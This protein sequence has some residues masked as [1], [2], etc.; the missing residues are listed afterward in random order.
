[1][2]ARIANLLCLLVALIWGGGFI[3]TDLA[4]ESFS[5][6]SMLVC[7]FIGAALFAWIPI[8][9]KKM[10]ITKAE[11]RT[12]LVSGIFLYLAFAFQTFGMEDAGPGMNAFLTSVNVI[13]V[14]YIVWIIYKKRPD[15]LICF[16]GVICLAGIGCLSLSNGEFYFGKGEILSLICAFFFALQI[17]SLEKV[18]NLNVMNVNAIQLTS[19][20]LCS[21]PFGLF[22]RWPGSLNSMAVLSMLYSIVLA[23]FVC[24]LLQTT[25]QKY[26]SASAASILLGTECL[27]AN[28]F[29]GLILHEPKS[30]IMIF[31]GILIFISILMVESKGFFL[32]KIRIDETYSPETQTEKE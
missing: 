26:T 12:G 19:A 9:M 31:G 10:A 8:L 30:P 18:Q 20:A 5:P 6:F 32:N 23:T 7:R 11:I 24:Y 4:L 17:V 28:I 29:S 14:P 27:W 3:A 16:A 13:L 1:M 15:R 21:I 2:S 22:A 25:A